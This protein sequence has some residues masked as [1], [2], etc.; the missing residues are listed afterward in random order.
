MTK[1]DIWLDN[2][3]D[4]EKNNLRGIP[5]PSSGWDYVFTARGPVSIPGQGT[6]VV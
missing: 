2:V 4:T 5:W 3:E 1:E 6:S